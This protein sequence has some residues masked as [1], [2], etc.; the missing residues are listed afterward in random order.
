MN[1]FQTYKKQ[2]LLALAAAGLGLGLYFQ[3]DGV[4]T[5]NNLVIPLLLVFPAA[6]IFAFYQSHQVINLGAFI[7][8]DSESLRVSNDG[9]PD[10]VIEWKNVREIKWTDYF[11]SLVFFMR[12]GARIEF[13]WAIDDYRKII[14]AIPNDL[15]SDTVYKG[16]RMYSEAG[17]CK[18]CGRKSVV[19][20]HALDGEDIYE[21]RVCLCEPWN[22]E[23][24]KNY[25]SEAE[26]VREMQTEH[27]EG[28]GSEEEFYTYNEDCGYE[29]DPSWKPSVSVEEISDRWSNHEE[30]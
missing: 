15:I 14:M 20:L 26:F 13:S 27:F 29:L 17:T 8:S 2:V 5:N 1:F 24:S 19:H 4:K 3:F 21:C 30:N 18:V 6:L 22:K 16:R 12:S 23:L 7:S 25:K 28:I 9:K 10:I 11:D